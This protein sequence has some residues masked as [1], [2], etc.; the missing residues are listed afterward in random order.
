MLK[1]TTVKHTIGPVILKQEDYGALGV[2]IKSSIGIGDQIQYS[3]LPENFFKATGK[4]LIDISRPWFFDFNPYVDR[5]SP[6]HRV[7]ECWNFGPRKWE[8]QLP[9]GRDIPVYT[10]NAEIIAS[11]FGVPVAVNR[12]RLYRFEHYPFYDRRMV[13]FQTEGRSHGP[14]PDHVIEHVMN[15]YDSHHLYHIG[16]GFDRLRKLWPLAQHWDTETLWDLARIISQSRMLIGMDSGPSWIAACFPD[17]I[18]KKLRTRPA[19]MEEYQNWIPLAKDNIHSHWDD[20]CH[21]V[22]N[23]TREDVGFTSTYLKI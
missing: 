11:T 2:S 1:T 14:M 16:P 7:I 13:L 22:F 6:A 18:V 20:R 12:P 5:E 8:W 23:P 3:S 10:S 4:K 19:S 17:V 21:Q 15:K 9:K